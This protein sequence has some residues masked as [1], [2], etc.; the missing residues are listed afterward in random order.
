MKK[1]MAGFVCVGLGVAT[2]YI[3]DGVWFG[4]LVSGASALVVLRLLRRD[5]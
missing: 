1:I 4:G 5:V 3:V 2:N